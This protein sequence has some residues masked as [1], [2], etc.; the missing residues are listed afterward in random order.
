MTLSKTCLLSSSLRMFGVL[1]VTGLLSSCT[2]KSGQW[3]YFTEP[4]KASVAEVL[5]DTDSSGD[6]WTLNLRDAQSI[7]LPVKVRPCCAF[8]NDQKVKVGP[9]KIPFYEQANTLDINGLGLHAFGSGVLSYQ[10]DELT[11]SSRFEHNGLI[12]TQRG[13][14]ID[15]AHVRDTADLTIALFFKIYPKLGEGHIIELIPELG[16]REIAFR[17]TDISHLS[18]RRRWLLAA[19][20]SA[21]L[22][23]QL[24]EAHEIAQWHGF[25]S[26]VPWSEELSAYSPED[27]YSNMLGGRLAK[28]LIIRNIAQN[29]T[30]FNQNMTLWFK[31]AMRY[32]EPVSQEQTQALLDVV[33]G[34]WWNSSI[35]MPE[36]YIL[37]KR[38]YKLGSTQTPFL[39]PE[40]LAK[41]QPEF[42]KTIK[43]LY[44]KKKYPLILSL[45]D[46]MYGF[47]LDQ[48]AELRLTIDKKY[49]DT[50]A[51]IPETLWKEQPITPVNFPLI[52]RFDKEEDKKRRPHNKD[53]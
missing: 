46:T 17:P 50:F 8:G 39:V 11:D 7:Q 27:L 36:K 48:M 28:A 10:H 38:N 37:L 29:E 15:T 52:A 40:D 26:F 22:A 33:D 16:P 23:Y 20:I 6:I 30:I 47:D 34:H 45:P 18:S 43:P 13:G 5:Q 32:L 51:H 21:R 44:K 25:R 42:W 41:S 4:S 9:V 53:Q 49:W 12:Y 19:N 31:A 3:S 24:A 1:L 14:F 2:T 35:A